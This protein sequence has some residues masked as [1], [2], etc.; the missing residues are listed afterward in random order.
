MPRR[1]P[2]EP[3]LQL[4]D[5]APML[6]RPARQLPRSGSWHFEFK[7][8][9]YRALAT[10]DQVRTRGGADATA[11]FPEI[12]AALAGLPAGHHIIDGEV[13]VMERGISN[14]VL[15]H[16]RAMRRRW[17]AGAAPVVFCAFDLLV[18]AGHDVRGMPIEA[19]K[20]RLAALVAGLPS[21]L[22]VSGIDDGRAAWAAVEALR[23][24]GIVAKRAG[25]IYVG[26]PSLDWLKIKRPGVH[27]HGA[28][29][30][31]L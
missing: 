28:F 3:A 25:S 20:A 18:H 2:A 17:Y 6:A 11:W 16:E 15:L 8:D 30:R 13:C 23:L 10:R 26:G 22:F 5:I 31:E 9:G 21:V 1:Q 7:H 29:K 14:F 19:R 4:P 24:E 27:D 12:P